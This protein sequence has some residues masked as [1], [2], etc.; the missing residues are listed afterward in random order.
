MIKM[1]IVDLD[2][3][4]SVEEMQELAASEQ[5][6]PVFDADSPEMTADMLLQFK[7]MNQEEHNI[8][9][10]PLVHPD[11]TFDAKMVLE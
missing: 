5:M 8:R 10:I 4:L 11:T 3:T 7:R 6:K 1:S 9:G 2:K